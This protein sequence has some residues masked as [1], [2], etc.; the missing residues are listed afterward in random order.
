MY[1]SPHARHRICQF[2]RENKNLAKPFQDKFK[3]MNGPNIKPK[4]R[5]KREVL[6][7]FKMSYRY[8]YY[9]QE[10]EDEDE[11]LD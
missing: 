9:N 4:R 10:K 11:D 8:K 3:E 2:E 1:K 6:G 5:P 7:G